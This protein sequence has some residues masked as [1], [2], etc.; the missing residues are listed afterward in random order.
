[1]AGKAVDKPPTS[2]FDFLIVEGVS[3]HLTTVVASSSQSSPWIDP[4]TIKLRQRIGRGVFGD[5]W[6]ATRHQTTADYDEYH[7]VAVKMLHPMKEDNI[8]L[9][10]DHLANLFTQCQGLQHV[11]WLQGLSVINGKLCIVMK[12]Y[13]GSIGDK[14]ARAKGGKMSLQD[15]IRYGTDLARGIMELHSKEILILNLKPHNFLL[16]ENDHAILGDIGIPYLFLGVPL[17]TSDMSRRLG[18]PNYMA[19]EQWQPE[20]RGPLSFETDSWGFGC[21]IVEMLTGSQPWS[22]K[23]VD[24]IHKAVVQKQ[25]K[26]HFPGGLPPAVENVIIGCFEYDFRNRPLSGDIFQAFLSSPEAA[27]GDG[28]W[29]ELGSR[30]NLDKLSG[31][32]Y[33]KW[34]V[35]KDQLQIRDTVRSRKPPNSC[36]PE[37]M[38]VPEGTIVGVERDTERNGFVLVRVHGIHDPLR[39]H[40]STLERVTFGLAAGDWVR[41]EEDR[42]KHSSVG[43]LH[44][45]YHDG[46]VAVAFVGLE[47]FWKGNCSELQMA[48]AFCARQFVRLKPDTFSPRFEWPRKRGGDWATGR[49]CQVLPNGCL[50][51]NFP[52]MLVF[53][54]KNSS[55]LADP[56]EVEIVSFNSSAGIVKKYKHLEDFHWAVRP[57]LVALGLFTATKLGLFV[58]KRVGRSKLKK[59]SNLVI[60]IEGQQGEVQT[61]GNAAWLPPKVAN[62]IFREGAS[63]TTTSR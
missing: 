29:R 62:I 24:E 1:M 55:F 34:L 27:Y 33:S 14:M 8:N 9:V 11:C 7:E 59:G 44:S 22:G 37:N 12:F 30:L 45:I 16:D 13:E 3:D 17:L 57:L 20:V 58:G 49:I 50:V 63:V 2:A 43:I 53:G 42:K 4:A 31:S 60:P 23:S 40:G 52:G 46:S 32:G 6:L 47:T 36:K 51:V 19:P 38:E 28:G 10:L 18:T 61:A 56:A 26:P 35:L 5:V 25:E 54:D 39:V 41:L 48:E 15:V 21:S